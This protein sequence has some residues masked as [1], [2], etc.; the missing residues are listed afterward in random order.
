MAPKKKKKALASNPARGFATTSIPAKPKAEE[1]VD[2]NVVPETALIDSN[3][4]ATTEN[5]G[6]N[7]ASSAG[8]YLS[9]LSPEELENYFEESALQ[10]LV[11][12]HG[13]KS[14]KD[15]S[16]QVNKLKTEQRVLR[17][18]SERLDIN[19]WLPQELVQLIFE[20]FESQKRSRGVGLEADTRQARCYKVTEEELIIKLWTLQQ[21]LTQLEFSNDRVQSALLS[22]LQKEHLTRSSAFSV[23]KDGLWGLEESLDFLA[24]VCEPEEM[25]SY[26]VQSASGQSNKGRKI[27]RNGIVPD[28]RKFSSEQILLQPVH[29]G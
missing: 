13:E 9:K 22:L 23:N 21:V 18:Q 12:K 25:P 4:V 7:I 16:R 17:L 5:V 2:D 14:K 19:S 8:E 10:I 29:S 3:A 11:E 24:Q 1:K 20:L 28:S 27:L 26:D 15:A 6:L